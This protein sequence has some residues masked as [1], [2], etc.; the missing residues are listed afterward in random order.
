MGGAADENTE[1]PGAIKNAWNLHV[2]HKQT[3]PL[4]SYVKGHGLMT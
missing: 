2:F 1:P 3:S 4:H